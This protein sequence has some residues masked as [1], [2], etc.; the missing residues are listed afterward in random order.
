MRL[1]E[2]DG[3]INFVDVNNVML[4]YD[5]HQTCC[6]FASWFISDQKK[7]IREE[8]ERCA[9]I[10]FDLSGYSFDPKFFDHVSGL[11]FDEGSMVIFRITN[12]TTEKFL[13]LFNV[14]NGYYGHGFDFVVGGKTC[15]GGCI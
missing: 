5:M 9:K 8:T 7:G 10:D 11:D 1:F 6:E 15:Q 4:G 2:K 12:G 3:K 13:H 14:Q